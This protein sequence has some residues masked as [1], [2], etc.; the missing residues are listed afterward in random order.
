MKTDLVQANT[1]LAT[2]PAGESP[3][4]PP[5]Q[6]A[7]LDAILAG[8]TAVNAAA[9]AG[10]ARSTL[11]H[12]LKTD[13]RFQAVLN[14]GRRDLQQ[15]VACRVERLAADASECVARAINNGDVKA[16]LEVLKRANVFAAAKIG[17]D[18]E[19]VL[20]SDAQR[21]QLDRETTLALARCS[22]RSLLQD[23]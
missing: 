17:S 7:A 8:K 11:Y 2:V 10:I 12:W 18:D 14:R 4:L 23:K 22:H 15:A 1:T 6:I 19:A 20:Q 3:E 13:F 21:R 16:A 9:A 5:A